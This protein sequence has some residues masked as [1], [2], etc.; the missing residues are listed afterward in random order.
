MSGFDSRKLR[1]GVERPARLCVM[2]SGGGRTLCN[3]HDLIESGGLGA[4]IEL[5]IASRA[6][7]GI[8][9]AQALGYEP[10][11]ERGRIVRER[12]GAML[13]ERQIDWVVLAG[14]LQ[15]VEIPLGYEQRVVN[16]HP[17][18]LPRFGGTGMFGDKVHA[19][20]LASG[21]PLSGC[22]VHLCDGEYDRGPIV[23]QRTCPVLA[24]DTVETL[25]ARVFGLEGDA[26]AAALRL[27][28]G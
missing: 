28:V 7:K 8:E 27:L 23:V 25:G 2:I 21:D 17:A 18:L 16:I 6:C 5:V 14:Y 4:R 9:R 12:L 22:T 26:Y 3:I 24:T 19:A 10:V 20:V 1:A 11:I 15:L 13:E